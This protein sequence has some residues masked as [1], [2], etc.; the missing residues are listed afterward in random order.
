MKKIPT[1]TKCDKS[2]IDQ[3]FRGGLQKSSHR[4]LYSAG[5]QNILSDFKLLE[6]TLISTA[7]KRSNLKKI[8]DSMSKFLVHY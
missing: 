1:V 4:N 8:I 6:E 5:G 7:S 3:V 2:N